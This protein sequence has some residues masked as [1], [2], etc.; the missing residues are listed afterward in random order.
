MKYIFV[1][2][3]L[4]AAL[5]SCNTPIEVDA[6][7]KT[8]TVKIIT[9]DTIYV[10]KKD[11][12]RVTDTVYV[13]ADTSSTEFNLLIV[14]T[15]FKLDTLPDSSLS[16][17][18]ELYMRQLHF[19]RQAK[20]YLQFESEQFGYFEFRRDNS[21]EQLLPGDKIFF[22]YQTFRDY[23]LI[24]RYITKTKGNQGLTFTI[25]DE[26]FSKKASITFKL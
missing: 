11:T 18:L 25:W 23:R 26:K 7:A 4:I 10:I 12:I 17:T 22:S 5:S 21:T 2:F 16:V 15:T 8:D 24:G 20:Y 6:K 19:N 9:R 3:A 13:K 14:P 1:F